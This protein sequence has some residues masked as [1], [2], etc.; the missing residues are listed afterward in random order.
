MCYLKPLKDATGVD[1]FNLAG[2]KDFVALK[3]E[4]DKLDVNKLTNAQVGLNNL[5][6][7]VDD[8]DVDKL[9][10]LSVNLKKLSHVVSKEFAKNT[11]FNKLNTQINNLEKKIPDYSSLI[12]TNQYNADKQNLEKLNGDVEGKKTNTSSLVNTT[13]LYAKIIEV[14]NKILDV[15]CLVTVSVLNTKIVEVENNIP[16]H[17]KYITT[18]EVN[19]FAGSIFD[20]KLK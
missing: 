4:V 16:G 3:V 1:T 20:T 10:T 7:I 9:K 18:P 11:K 2:K 17:A 5:K 14:E 15:S 6:T 19:K 12:Q 13:V 8:L